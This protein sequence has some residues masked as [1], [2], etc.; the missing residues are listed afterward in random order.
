M[1]LLSLPSSNLTIHFLDASRGKPNSQRIRRRPRPH[2]R[3]RVHLAARDHSS[4][5]ARPQTTLPQARQP[6]GESLLTR[7][8]TLRT[9]TQVIPL[10]TIETVEQEVERLLEADA[11][12]SD[13]KYEILENVNPDLSD[14]EFIDK[15]GAAGD[16]PTPFPGSDAGDPTTPGPDHGEGEEDGGCACWASVWPDEVG[17]CEDAPPIV[18]PIAC[19]SLLVVPFGLAPWSPS[20]A[21]LLAGLRVL[22]LVAGGETSSKLGGRKVWPPFSSS[23][24]RNAVTAVHPECILPPVS[25]ESFERL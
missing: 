4:T 23:T 12:A 21:V 22:S 9:F 20:L 5:Q 2:Q 6:Q 17:E 14:S 24:R 13:V 16:A 15:P 11:L 1:S 18:L 7:P 25:S 8:F 10:Q 3:R 19:R